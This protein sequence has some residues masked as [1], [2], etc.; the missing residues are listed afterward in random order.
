MLLGLMPRGEGKNY[1]AQTWLAEDGLPQN[2]V[3]AL[4]YARDGYLWVG[5]YNGLAR[6]DGV[7]FD[8]F[9]ASKTT[10][11][12]GSRIVFLGEDSLRRI[13][14]ATEEGAVAYQTK[15]GEFKTVELPDSA[16]PE[17]IT[18]M[19]T[20]ADGAIW[21]TWGDG[22]VRKYQDGHFVEDRS[23]WGLEWYAASGVVADTAG[24]LWLGT[25]QGLLV[26]QD[27]RFRPLTAE[28]VRLGSVSRVYTSRTGGVWAV[29]ADRITLVR[30]REISRQAELPP[31]GN[32]KV[33]GLAEGDGEDV[34][35]ATSGKGLIRI[36]Q[37]KATSDF[38]S[39]DGLSE[40]TVR[41]IC[42]DGEGNLWVGTEGA[43]LNR[44]RRGPIHMIAPPAGFAGETVMACA[45]DPRSGLVWFASNGTGLWTWNPAT[46]QA[47]VVGEEG[48]PAKSR[49]SAM[50][51]DRKGRLLLA[52]QNHGLFIREEGKLNRLAGAEA[53]SLLV[54]AIHVDRDNRVWFGGRGGLGSLDGSTLRL[55]T[56]ADG[57]S[58]LDIR[59]ITEDQEGRI[60]VGTAGG[61]LNAFAG[62]HWTTLRETNGLP[63]DDIWSLHMDRRGVLWVGT[64][65]SG[66]ARLENG[67][68]GRISTREG[69]PDDVISQ[70]AEDAQGNIWTST[71]NGIARIG[72]EDGRG[73][74]LVRIFGKAD[75]LASLE[76]AATTHSSGLCLRDGRLL[77]ST[78]KGAAWIDPVAMRI[79][80]RPPPVVIESAKIDD[81]EP[82]QANQLLEVPPEHDRLEIAY[83][84][85]GFSAPEKM[86][87]RYKLEGLEK[88]WVDAGAR[89]V[90]YYSH[91][92][93]GKYTFRVAAM[94]ED[95][96][97]NTGGA[98]MGIVVVPFYY[99]TGWF[100]GTVTA[101]SLAAVFG[102]LRYLAT[103]NYRRQ[104]ATLERERV[105]ERERT[106]IARDI[107]DDLGA[108]L[109]QIALLS[110]L[111]RRDVAD[112]V[113]HPRLTQHLRQI[114]AKARSLTRA[115]DEI[116]WAVNPRND[117]LEEFLSY[118]AKYATDYLAA[119]NIRCRLDLPSVQE[120]WPLSSET[121]HHLFLW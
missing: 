67:R 39:S 115:M 120:P 58:S 35:L 104:M 53:S 23:G 27:G 116:V 40:D 76:S 14:T 105:V 15:F 118:F 34:W 4:L 65:G 5:T 42:R 94:N 56:V 98:S 31:L 62:K 26:W 52:I 66:I 54:H 12:P 51:F 9:R 21:F 60:W 117:S 46:Q 86:R 45:Q 73:K 79:N 44:L 13:W 91:V 82:E 95:G 88:D 100:V 43:G 16:R 90:A 69:L 92:R 33:M 64:F 3:N 17:V 109:T 25:N 2:S 1:V 6:F 106:R 72:G 7:K 83:T 41:S 47:E 74:P 119:A 112:S 50:Q 85:L 114:S 11:L 77:F 87:F 19:A 68:I 29:S 84:A 57:L 36:Q 96:I 89:R 80:Q 38:N 32:A 113:S 28:G 111:A 78:T 99:Q 121:R 63:S 20:G 49:V 81:S 108:S 97:W 70:I 110:E 102:L 37:G 75:G 93:P 22:R 71:F 103:R 18:S 8:T 61:G 107:H 48:L 10:G 30:K 59:A 24:D 101:L 55:H